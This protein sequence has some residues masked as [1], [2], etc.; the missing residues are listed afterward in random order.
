[1]T[2]RYIST[3]GATLP[4]S[5]RQAT[6]T[7]LAPDGG[8]YLPDKL[9]QLSPSDIADFAFMRY[10]ECAA[11]I[12]GLFTGQDLEQEQLQKIIT[13]AYKPFRHQAIAPLHQIDHNHWILELFHG[14]TLAFKDFALQ[15][16]GGL[17]ETFLAEEKGSSPL[18]SDPMVIVG[19]T[20]GDTGS[21]AIHAL[22][23][24]EGITIFMLHPEGRISDVQRRQMTTVIAPNVHNIAVAGSFDDC[25]AMVKQLLNDQEFRS[26]HRM[27]VVN[28]INWARLAAQVVYYFYAA[29]RL[30]APERKLAFSVP[31]GNFGDAFAGILA[32]RMGLPVEAILIATNSNDILYRALRDGDYST[33]SLHQTSSP[34]MDI[35]ISSN[36]ERLLFDY[37]DRDGQKLGQ[38][39]SEFD[40][41]GRLVL[42][43]QRIGDLF[44]MLCGYRA[45]EDNV[46]WMMRHIYETTGMVID[47]HTAVACHAVRQ[48]REEYGQKIPVVTLSTAHAAKFSQNVERF[49]GKRPPTPAQISGLFDREER[50]V[51]LPNDPE[52]LKAL[53]TK[54]Q[55]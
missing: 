10:Q 11:H 30:G 12:L 37:F 36:F 4:V 9:P 17:F 45:D 41:T 29:V 38:A 52:A 53:I 54:T 21:A 51:K 27:S 6:M 26:Q 33:E 1:M 40:A 47:P 15:V 28:S 2:I 31:T 24:R 50:F 16:L 23:G 3:R 34:S 32:M 8:L 14:P 13:T 35:Q 25:Q 18:E 55:S 46:A 42:D 5:F 39:M 22:A 49:V 20:S 43:L 7:G 44:P 19:A 48:W